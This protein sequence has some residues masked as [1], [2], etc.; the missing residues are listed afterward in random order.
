MSKVNRS[1]TQ[2]SV[3]SS[4]LVIALGILQTTYLFISFVCRF[5]SQRL[6]VRDGRQF[7]RY[8]SACGSGSKHKKASG[9]VHRLVSDADMAVHQLSAAGKRASR[10][11]SDRSSL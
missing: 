8:G 6:T 1:R 9:M 11:G 2:L 3:I 10:L 7:H 4:V 5:L